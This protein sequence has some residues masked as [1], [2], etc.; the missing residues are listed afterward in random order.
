[1]GSKAWPDSLNC[2]RFEMDWVISRAHPLASPPPSPPN[3]GSQISGA[4]LT[5]RRVRMSILPFLE[6]IREPI[7][8]LRPNR[9]TD[10]RGFARRNSIGT[11]LGSRLLSGTTCR[12]GKTEL[13]SSKRGTWITAA[14]DEACRYVVGSSHGAEAG[15]KEERRRILEPRHNLVPACSLVRLPGVRSIGKK[16]INP[17]EARRSRFLFFFPPLLIYIL[18]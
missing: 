18:H 5:E 4:V 16:D 2:F 3:S 15:R 17:G 9:R 14:D 6:K 10:Q 1:M 8:V 11:V 7:V 12:S 13:N